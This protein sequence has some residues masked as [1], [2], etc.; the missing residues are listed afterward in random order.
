MLKPVII[1]YFHCDIQE[2]IYEVVK[3]VEEN[4]PS[5]RIGVS[6]SQNLPLCSTD[7]GM[8]EQV[9]YNLLNNAA[10]H[11]EQNSR[12]EISAMCH[13]DLLQI[14]VEDS[15]EGFVDVDVK[16]VFYKFSRK[17]VQKGSGSGLGLS[18]VKGF[19]EALG[20][21]VELQNKK[22]GGAFFSIYIPVKTSSLKVEV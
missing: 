1:V 20:G 6:M 22:I 2:L 11:T 18:I 9:I 7:K 4:N 14:V 21:T 10:F 13:A 12:I 15:G 17:R 16:D 8:L 3:R 19:T 5:R